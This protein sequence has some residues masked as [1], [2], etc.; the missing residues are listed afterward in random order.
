MENSEEAV[1]SRDRWGVR[2]RH[3]GVGVRVGKD[4]ETALESPGGQRQGRQTH[5]DRERDSGRDRA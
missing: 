5:G 2:Q 1:G 3:A 4:G